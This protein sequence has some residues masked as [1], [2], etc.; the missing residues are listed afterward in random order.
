MNNA[1]K[2]TNWK[3]YFARYK[4]N[5]L[6]LYFSKVARNQICI[7]LDKLLFS[8]IYKKKVNIL[9]FGTSNSI[10][11]DSNPFLEHLFKKKI[12]LTFVDVV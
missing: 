5:K 8:K 7:N 2:I 9:D 10:N 6:A 11:E 3:N 4:K 12:N 1:K